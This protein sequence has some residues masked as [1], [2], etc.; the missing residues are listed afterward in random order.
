M[1][2]SE[3]TED[4]TVNIVFETVAKNAVLETLVVMYKKSSTTTEST[5]TN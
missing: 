3:I 2:Y 1:D 5:N 4:P